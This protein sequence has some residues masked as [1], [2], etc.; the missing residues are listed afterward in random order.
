MTKTGAISVKT[1]LC[2]NNLY[3]KCWLKRLPRWAID[4]NISHVVK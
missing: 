4:K 1:G 3:S 2:T